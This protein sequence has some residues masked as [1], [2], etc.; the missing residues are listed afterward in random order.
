M[1]DYSQ[2]SAAENITLLKPHDKAV[3][4]QLSDVLASLLVLLSLITLL[5]HYGNVTFS[6]MLMTSL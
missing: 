4:L 3:L 2:I 1:I 5:T 6:F